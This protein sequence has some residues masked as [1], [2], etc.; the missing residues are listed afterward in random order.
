MAT[1]LDWP[2]AVVI[3]AALKFKAPVSAIL[4]LPEIQYPVWLGVFSS[5]SAVDLRMAG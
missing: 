2:S 4:W 1:V 5:I 3:A